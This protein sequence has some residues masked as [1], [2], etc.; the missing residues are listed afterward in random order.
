MGNIRKHQKNISSQSVSP[1][2][3]IHHAVDEAM[4]DFYSIFDSTGSAL[5]RLEHR[6]LFPAMDIV[7]AGDHFEVELE[8]PGLEDDDIDISLNNNILTI[9][10]EKTITKENKDKNYLNR[11]ISYGSYERS[12]ELPKTADAEK[13]TA[14]FSSGGILCVNIPKKSDIKKETKKIKVEKS[15]KSKNQKIKK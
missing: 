1:F 2:L 8:M 9:K 4:K 14:N 6:S 7:D 11:E 12:L 10:G 13:A 15:A 5:D 3:G